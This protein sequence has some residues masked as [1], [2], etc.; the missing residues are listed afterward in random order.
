METAMI[1]G[2]ITLFLAFWI[3]PIVLGIRA[4]AAKGISPHWMWFGLHP[5]GAWIAF[6]VI[7][8]GVRPRKRCP[9]CAETLLSHA[10]T[11][12]Y[13]GHPF[14]DSK[15][16]AEGP[17]V[18]SRRTWIIVG[19]VAVGFL[20]LVGAFAATMFAVVSASFDQS[21]VVHQAVAQVQGNAALQ[22]R[23]GAPIEKGRMSSGTINESGSDGSA[24]VDIPL[25]GPNGHGDLYAV[26]TKSA[27]V[28]TFSTLAFQPDGSSE[29]MDLLKEVSRTAPSPVSK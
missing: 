25:H 13:C 27:G 16:E 4:A 2:A 17:P 11:C 5:F 14:D 6:F 3:V 28:W 1:I 20:L 21:E 29:R 12:A 24:D 18:T 23:L 7:R 19:A 9:Q 10:K 15:P 8:L 22:A 26:A